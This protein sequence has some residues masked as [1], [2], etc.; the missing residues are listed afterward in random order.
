MTIV[1]DFVDHYIMH[2]VLSVRIAR[3]GDLGLEK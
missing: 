2:E 3:Q 1:V